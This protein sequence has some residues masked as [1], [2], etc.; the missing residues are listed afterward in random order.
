MESHNEILNKIIGA[1][2]YNSLLK[3]CCDLFQVGLLRFY[4]EISEILREKFDLYGI[5]LFFNFSLWEKLTSYKNLF[6]Y[7]SSSKN[8]KTKQKWFEEILENI[9]DILEILNESHFTFQFFKGVIIEY[10]MDERLDL[11]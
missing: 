8:L 1:S 10:I 4:Y 6:N 7:L 9:P 11:I 3:I 5:D 2:N